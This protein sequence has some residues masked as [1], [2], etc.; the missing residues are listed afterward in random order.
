MSTANGARLISP[1]IHLNDRAEASSSFHAARVHIRI[2]ARVSGAHI[3][4]WNMPVGLGN[5]STIQKHNATFV[6]MD[7]GGAWGLAL[8][9]HIA[10]YKEEISKSPA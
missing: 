10:Q 6:T 1:A 8:L 4:A 5:V 3:H 7:T 9:R 2:A